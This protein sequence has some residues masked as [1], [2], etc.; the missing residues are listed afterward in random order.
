MNMTVILHRP[1]SL[2]IIPCDFFPIPKD[3]IEAQGAT[4]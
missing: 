1:Y 2:N 3:E 4:F